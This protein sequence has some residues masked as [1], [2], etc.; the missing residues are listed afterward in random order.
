MKLF[1]GLYLISFAMALVACAPT[2][3]CEYAASGEWP[4]LPPDGWSVADQ[5]KYT[6]EM[7]GLDS[8]IALW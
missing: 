1:W 2:K 3:G 6:R 4:L 5:R 8:S 7:C